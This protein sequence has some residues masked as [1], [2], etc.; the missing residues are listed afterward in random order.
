M[1]TCPAESARQTAASRRVPANHV[2]QAPGVCK[3]RF[4]GNTVDPDIFAAINVCELEFRINF[5]PKKF[6]V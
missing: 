6:V 1:E 4:A 5:V 3:F 2:R